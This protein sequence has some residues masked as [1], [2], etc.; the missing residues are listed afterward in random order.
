[1]RNVVV[2]KR[3]DSNNGFTLIEIT[4]VLII[5]SFLFAI[6]GPRIAKGL[7][8]LSLTTSTKKIAAALRYAR[9]Q[10]VNKAQAYSVIFDREHAQIVIRG[11]PKPVTVTLPLDDTA[12]EEAATEEDTAE[13]RKAVVNELKVVPVAEGVTFQEISIGGQEV[14]GGKEELPQMIFFP[15][16]TSQGGDIVLANNREQAF[17]VSVD[18]LTGVVTIAEKTT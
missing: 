8:G 2:D 18:F 4:I 1:M 6:A 11:I 14:T 9:S 17:T 7:S 12:Q 15:D 5:I 16:G 10:A 3:C 13:D